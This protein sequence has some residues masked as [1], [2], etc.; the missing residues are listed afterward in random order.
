MCLI[1]GE[2]AAR[3]VVEEAPHATASQ[4]AARTR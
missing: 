2:H 4:P 3:A 1:S